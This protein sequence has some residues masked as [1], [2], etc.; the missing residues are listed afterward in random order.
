MT[1]APRIT[2][3][4]IAT[5]YRICGDSWFKLRLVSDSDNGVAMIQRIYTL[6]LEG[7]AEAA[8]CS[9]DGLKTFGAIQLTSHG[10]VASVGA[11]T[12]V[13]RCVYVYVLL[14][15]QFDISLGVRY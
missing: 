7:R 8:L 5:Q 15:E 4:F 1:S 13:C 14:H 3:L 2:S 9:P 12:C 10:G 6:R 11:F